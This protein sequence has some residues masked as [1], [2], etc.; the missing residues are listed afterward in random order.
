MTKILLINDIACVN[1]LVKHNLE[2]EGFSVETSLNGEDGVT[3][4]MADKFDIIL[5]DYNMPG[6]D[7]GQVCKI[8]KGDDTVKDV[9][10]YFISALDK[11]AMDRV[12]KDTGACGHID[13]SLDIGPL[14]AKINEAI[15]KSCRR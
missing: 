11:D 8:L 4:A 1:K 10:I 9:P 2:A 6:M 13:I 3:K 12:I 7:G 5:L 15:E 14:I